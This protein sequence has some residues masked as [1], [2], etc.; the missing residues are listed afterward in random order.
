[1]NDWPT[2]QLDNSTP[3][4]LLHT[5]SKLHHENLAP[6]LLMNSSSID[7]STFWRCIVRQTCWSAICWAHGQTEPIDLN[8]PIKNLDDAFFYIDLLLSGKSSL[9]NSDGAYR[10]TTCHRG[11][12][13]FW[14]RI[15]VQIMYGSVTYRGVGFDHMA[16]IEFDPIVHITME[17]VTALRLQVSKLWIDKS[18]AETLA[19]RID[20]KFRNSG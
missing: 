8:N 12:V 7:E 15:I 5:E 2:D 16:R 4:L 11:R 3:I 19:R 18:I 13:G 20:C 6:I 17:G 9:S 10:S 14:A 1:M